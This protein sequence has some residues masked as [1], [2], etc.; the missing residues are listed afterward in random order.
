MKRNII[1]SIIISLAIGLAVGIYDVFNPIILDEC[2]DWANPNL[3][4]SSSE[5]WKVMIKDGLIWTLLVTVASFIPVFLVY[6]L[7]RMK[8]SKSAAKS[9]VNLDEDNQ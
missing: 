2:G 3:Y 8:K 4:N 6:T 9:A 7:Y 1:I 5:Y